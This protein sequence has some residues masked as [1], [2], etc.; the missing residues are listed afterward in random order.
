MWSGNNVLATSPPLLF[1]LG[2]FVR[3]LF[4]QVLPLY[5]IEFHI[6]TFGSSFSS[7][8]HLSPLVTFSLLFC[9]NRSSTKNLL[10]S[11][12]SYFKSILFRLRFEWKEQKRGNDSSSFPSSRFELFSLNSYISILTLNLSRYSLQSFS[13]Y[14]FCSGKICLVLS[15]SHTNTHTLIPLPLLQGRKNCNKENCVRVT[16][17]DAFRTKD[18]R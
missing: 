18:A 1:F 3:V 14:H 2:S 11:F 8:N 9:F 17:K 13:S 5:G 6:L 16:K 4:L 15:L 12:T 7:F 10:S